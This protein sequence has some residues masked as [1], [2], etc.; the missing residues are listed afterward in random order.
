MSDTELNETI[1]KNLTIHPDAEQSEFLQGIT[2]SI[3]ILQNT[4]ANVNLNTVSIKINA[5]SKFIQINSINELNELLSN[6][7]IH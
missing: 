7:M 4:V 3:S 5:N 1:R 6:R 2:D